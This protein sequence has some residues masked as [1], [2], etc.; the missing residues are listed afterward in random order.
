MIGIVMGKIILV[1]L[2]TICT[3]SC[4]K[5]PWERNVNKASSIKGIKTKILTKDKSNKMKTTQEIQK[6]FADV[7]YYTGPI[8]GKFSR[9]LRQAIKQFQENNGLTPDGEVGIKTKLKLRE[10]LK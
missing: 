5:L 7:G 9:A 8:D 1:L 2:L 10:F 4:E 6:A 3:I